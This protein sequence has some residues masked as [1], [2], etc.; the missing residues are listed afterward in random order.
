RSTSSNEFNS[1]R[2]LLGGGGCGCM[3]IVVAQQLSEWFG[4]C[5][6]DRSN[7]SCC[8]NLRPEPFCPM[9][10][11]PASLLQPCLCRRRGGTQSRRESCGSGQSDR[12]LPA[13]PMVRRG[14]S[15]DSCGF[16]DGRG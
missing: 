11:R 5:D 13:G 7:A 4:W 3:H 2:F 12:C 9:Q 10:R 1:N 6:A 8:D 16:Y 14:G 15:R